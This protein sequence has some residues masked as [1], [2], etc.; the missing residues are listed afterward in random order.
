MGLK[1]R[2]LV[3]LASAAMLVWGCGGGGDGGGGGG[4]LTSGSRQLIG[5]AATGAALARASVVITDASGASACEESDVTTTV[6]GKY[7]CTL[8]AGRLAPYF[9]VVSD[10]AGNSTALVSVATD[11]PAAGQ[12]VIV[13]ATPLTTSILGQLAPIGPAHTLAAG[14]SLDSNALRVLTSNVVAQLKPVLTSLGAPA[15]YDPFTSN[16]VAAT[17]A[18]TGNAADMVLDVVKVG[19]DP[20]TGKAALVTVD[21]TSPVLM[22]T[23]SSAGAALPVPDAKLQPLIRGL[24]LVARGFETCFSVPAAQRVLAVDTSVPYSQGGPRVTMFGSACANLVS[25]ASNPGQVEFLQAGFDAGQFIYASLTSDS[26]TGSKY[27]VPELLAFY[28]AVSTA[29]PPSIDAYDRAMVNMKFVDSRGNPG[30]MISMVARLP[31]SASLERPSEWWLVGDQLPTEVVPKAQLRRIEQLNP[32]NTA[33]FSTF[34]SGV[35]FSFNTKGPGS[36][37]GGQPLAFVRVAGPGLPG[38]GA[39]G[40]GVV[41]RVSSQPSQVGMDLFNKTGSLTVGSQCGNGVAF[42]CPNIWL[43]RTRGLTGA[44]ATTLVP[45]PN[46]TPQTAHIWAQPGEGFDERKFLRGASYRVEFFYGANTTTP[47]MTVHRSLFTDLISATAG[48]KLPW[49]TPGANWLAAMDP[50]GSF[51]GAQSQLFVDW[52]QD[53]AAPQVSGVQ[54]VVDPVTG[55]FGAATPAARGATSLNLH[56]TVPAFDAGTQRTIQMN[57]RML[58]WSGKSATY[59]WN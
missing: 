32:A 56:T 55:S 58:D 29:I 26:T 48:A 53:P 11:V 47:G 2:S 13:N 46:D 34:Q 37:V 54:A 19:L 14:G 5:T 17:T 23:A 59:T 42:N 57:Y 20:V 4:A 18:N 50:G 35:Q 8:K 21:S 31:G 7:S 43:S 52:I 30:N 6:E 24:Q 40:S 39:A 41:Y 51:A 1:V 33:K 22:A 25:R 3:V 45:N 27:S 15:D 16:I 12:S 36:I 10:P 28:P 44:D 38:D 49:N 9:V